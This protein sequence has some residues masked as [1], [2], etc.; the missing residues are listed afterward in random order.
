MP[1]NPL[2]YLLVQ[3][4]RPS[5]KKDDFFML[6]IL[7]SKGVSFTFNGEEYFIASQH[8]TIYKEAIYK[9]NHDKKKVRTPIHCTV[10]ARTNDGKELVAHIYFG[11]E[12]NYLFTEIKQTKPD[13]KKI[14]SHN[15]KDIFWEFSQTYARPVLDSLFEELIGEQKK[16]VDVKDKNL[17]ALVSA[18]R[19]STTNRKYKDLLKGTIETL[20]EYEQWDFDPDYGI[21]K[22]LTDYSNY[23]TSREKA[24]AAAALRKIKKADEVKQPDEVKQDPVLVPVSAPEKRKEEIPDTNTKICVD[25]SSQLQHRL[26]VLSQ[27]FKDCP[28]E[29]IDQLL[30]IIQKI[31][32]TKKLA[33]TALLIRLCIAG[34]VMLFKRHFAANLNLLDNIL[35]SA[36][37]PT[38][39]YHG[40]TELFDYIYHQI[41]SHNVKHNFCGSAYAS[42]GAEVTL[43]G[44]D[45]CSL[46]TMAFATRNLAFFK[47]LLKEYKYPP[48]FARTNALTA[49]IKADATEFAKALLKA[50]IDPNVATYK[51]LSHVFSLE[52]ID[53]LDEKKEEKRLLAVFTQSDIQ[54]K[55]DEIN[56]Q[57]VGGKPLHLAV[58]KNNVKVV[59]LLLKYGAVFNAETDNGETPFDYAVSRGADKE[60]ILEF[61]KKGHKIDEKLGKNPTTGL[62]RACDSQNLELVR[63]LI[64]LGANPCVEHKNLKTSHGE[65]LEFHSPLIVTLAW[66]NMLIL[67]E[68]FKCPIK[69]SD[70]ELTYKYCKKVG[71]QIPPMFVEKY[72]AVCLDDLE[73]AK[74]ALNFV[75]AEKLYQEILTMTDDKELKHE[76]L[77]E[78]A[79]VV[80]EKEVAISRMNACIAIREE[81]A[82]DPVK[83]ERLRPRI[84]EA[85]IKLE[86]IK[87]SMV[88]QSEASEENAV[89]FS[90]RMGRS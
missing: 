90:P 68:L 38:C 19:Q 76:I 51:S 20:A 84:N 40:H 55:C 10:T 65:I 48:Q 56:K 82:R 1:A 89:S 77:Y 27:Q 86:S 34:D 67:N 8:L 31:D 22:K 24:L 29:D 15:D 73:Q 79:L 11:D 5:I 23:L 42:I 12:A 32:K 39:V 33:E 54:K 69:Q 14:A 17:D 88:A 37:L 6:V 64:D 61:L 59:R 74:R 53:G 25:L 70:L 7:S 36:L 81:L 35:L 13:K 47:K 21:K 83:A 52:N 80:K 9:R 30:S 58:L 57:L 75:L 85:K 44:T 43:V 66:K 28:E 18:S 62:F 60:I 3:R 63:V 16:I 4:P 2:H 78:S 87:G 46:L 45:D 50:G 26:H 71:I 49:T 72:V 41:R